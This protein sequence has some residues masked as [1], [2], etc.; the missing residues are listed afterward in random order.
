MHLTNV[1]DKPNNRYVLICYTPTES[2]HALD[3]FLLELLRL[4]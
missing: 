1:E 3:N 2:Y 4:L